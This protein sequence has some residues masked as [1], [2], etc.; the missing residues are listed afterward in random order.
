VLRQDPDGIL[1][2]EMRDPETIRAALTAAET[3]HLVF[4]T[5]HTN[6]VAQS[7]D[8]IID[9]FPADQQG[10]IRSQLAASL[11]AIIAQRLLPR[12]GEKGGRVAA[13]EILIGT[14]AVKAMIRDKKTHQLSGYMETAAKDGMITMDRALRDLFEAGQITRETYLTMA[15]NPVT[16]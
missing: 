10:Q 7:V 14:M 16:F 9:V 6:D 4:A 2:G 1:M 12:R 13:F 5:L 15:R 8:R 11:E 3:G